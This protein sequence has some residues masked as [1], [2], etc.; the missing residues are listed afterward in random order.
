MALGS[1]VRTDCQ[2]SIVRKGVV[3]V[4]CALLTVPLAAPAF[5]QSSN[6]NAPAAAASVQFVSVESDI[7]LEVLDWGGT[8]RPLVL[9]AGLG[10]TAHAFDHFAPKL[11][12]NYH[13]YGITRRG[14]GQS[15]TPA[16][17]PANYTADRLGDD[18]LAVCKFLKLDR[19]VLAGHSIAGEELSSIGFRHPEKVAGLVYLDATA[20]Y[21]FYD[22][23]QG[24]FLLDLYDLEEKLQ[25]LGSRNSAANTRKPV[26]DIRPIVRE[27]RQT[28]LPQFEKDLQVWE[29]NV[30][31]VPPPPPAPGPRTPRDWAPTLIFGGEQKFTEIRAPVLAIIAVPHDLSYIRDPGTRAK[32]QAW[33]EERM[34]A[35]A[36]AFETGVPT[37]RVVRL[38]HANHLV[39]QSNEADVLR[40]IKLSSLTCRSRC[41]AAERGHDMRLVRF[42]GAMS[43]DGYIAGPGGEYDW[44]VMDPDFDFSEH[45]GSV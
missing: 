29:K 43:L 9:L 28:I 30:E 7:K 44:I 24:D 10:G 3:G 32:A 22:R 34:S 18:V 42:G 27:L 40:E 25:D 16:P 12:A 15:G 39:Y 14:F 20:A 33:D 26:S 17:I 8:G 21:A 36:K 41:A 38:A 5:A 4:A 1:H 19:P 6:L 11:I 2:L 31:G 37:A 13:V 23:S 45:L 35:Q